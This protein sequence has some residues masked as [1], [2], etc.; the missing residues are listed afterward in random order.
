MEKMNLD[1]ISQLK[2]EHREIELR[3]AELESHLSLSPR[4]QHE[5]A[6]LKKLKLAKKDAIQRLTRGRPAPM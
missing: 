5:R 6:E 2:N 1:P 4:E 3:L